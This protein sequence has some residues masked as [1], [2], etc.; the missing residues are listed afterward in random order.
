[1]GI[2]HRD[3]KP[4]NIFLV[5]TPSMKTYVK[6]L[7]FGIAK[8]L[9][10]RGPPLTR[11]D[12]IVGS[13]S[14]MP[15]EQLAAGEISPRSDLYSVGVVLYELVVGVKPYAASNVREAVSAI[16]RGGAPIPPTLPPSLAGVVRKAISPL[17]S[18]RFTSAR[19]M[20]EALEAA[21]LDTS[22]TPVLLKTEPIRI[23]LRVN[24]SPSST[25]PAHPAHPAQVALVTVPLLHAPRSQ[26]GQRQGASPPRAAVTA[27]RVLIGFA[28]LILI[29]AVA[30]VLTILLHR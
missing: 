13:L 16:L 27:L 25:V 2:V 10:T 6:V 8:L 12:E 5:A 22:T 17:A 3:I 15:P 23:A 7:D 11:P 28:C 18:E 4:D 20:L 24:E 26:P 19:E 1:M 14:Y 21:H 30:T 9:D 29:G